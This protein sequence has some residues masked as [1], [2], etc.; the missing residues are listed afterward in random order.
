MT[1][2]ISFR[3]SADGGL[4]PRA[5]AALVV[6]YVGLCSAGAAATVYGIGSTTDVSA[7]GNGPLADAARAHIEQAGSESPALAVPV[8]PTPGSVG[9]FTRTVGTGTAT[10]TASG[11][12]NDSYAIQIRITVG[13]AVGTARFVMSMDGGQTWEPE[14]FTAA[15]IPRPSDGITVAFPV[16]TYVAGDTFAAV[17]DGPTFT[18]VALLAAMDAL[19]ASSKGFGIVHVLGEAGGANDAARAAASAAI[20][21]SLTTKVAAANATQKRCFR[22]VME[23]PRVPDA[24]LESAF[25]GVAGADNLSIAVVAAWGTVELPGTLRLPTINLGRVIAARLAVKPLGKDPSAYSDGPGTGPLPASVRSITRDERATPAL[26]AARFTTTK[27]FINEPGYYLEGMPLM[28]QAGSR[29]RYIQHGQC[30]DAALSAGRPAMLPFLSKELGVDDTGVISVGQAES[31]RSEVEKAVR[32]A[33][34]Q[35]VSNLAVSVDR[36]PPESGIVARLRLLPSGY[37]KSGTLDHAL[38]ASLPAAG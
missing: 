32:S 29:Y 30:M 5:S 20:A 35:H 24:A 34:A 21:A 36:I 7:L 8:A 3:G 4:A 37:A 31:I 27:T 15:S 19:I 28:A 33:V 25:A 26:N 23:A 16:G 13:G 6:A 18:T 17:A 2:D 9:A 14:A 38:V 22:L 11:A 1:Q 10:P 12:P